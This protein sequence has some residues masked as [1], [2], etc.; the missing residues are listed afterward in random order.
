[1]QADVSYRIKFS[2]KIAASDK[3]KTLDEVSG[4]V[5]TDGRRDSNDSTVSKGLFVSLKPDAWC[6]V[7]NDG[8]TVG[9]SVASLPATEAPKC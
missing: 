1:M 9:T 3:E 5:A 6:I 7:P 4:V 8:H 2:N